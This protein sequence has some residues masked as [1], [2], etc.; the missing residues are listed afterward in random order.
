M[1][2]PTSTKLRARNIDFAQLDVHGAGK[3]GIGYGAIFHDCGSYCGSSNGNVWA[4][5]DL[6]Q[7]NFLINFY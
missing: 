4:Y 3:N 2:K 7:E 6:C 5:C 1:K